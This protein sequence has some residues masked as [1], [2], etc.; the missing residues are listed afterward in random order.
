MT[1]IRQKFLNFIISFLFCFTTTSCQTTQENPKKQ[2]VVEIAILMPMT[3]VNSVFGHQYNQLIKMGLED[4]IKTHIKVTS[5][6]GSDEKQILNAMDKIVA[7]RTK[8]ILGPLYSPLTS[9]IAERAKNHGITMITMSNNPALADKK[10][11]VFGHAPLKQLDRIVN[12]FLD[13]DYKNVIALLPAGQHSQTVS[14]IIQ[15][16]VVQKNG[17][18]VRAEFYSDTPES[19]AKSVSLVSDSVDNLNEMDDVSTKP[20]IYLADDPKNLNLLFDTINKH[21]LDKKAII[22]G[23]NRLDIDYPSYINITFTGSLNIINGSVADRAKELG[24]NHISFMHAMSYDLGKMVANYIGDNFVEQNFIARMNSKEPYIGI[25]GNIYFVD[26]IAQREYDV[27]KKED[28]LY[29]TISSGGK[30]R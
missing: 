21:N 18:Y 12:Y 4:G 25:S 5:Y 19:I 17:T 23:D 27:I 9:L 29:T 3:G 30:A 16:F 14:K 1:S 6:D 15:D 22:A 24:I 2:E 20:V 13:S 11:F 7:R 10:L 28:A 26:S 8:I